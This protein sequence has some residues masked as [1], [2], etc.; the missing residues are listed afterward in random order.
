MIQDKWD[1]KSEEVPT[2]GGLE[3]HESEHQSRGHEL[4]TAPTATGSDQHVSSDELWS[5]ISASRRGA[6]SPPGV[7]G[8]WAQSTSLK[9]KDF[10]LRVLVPLTEYDY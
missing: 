9:Y 5:K 3:G 6:V 7:F 8:L 1:F 4:P 10:S 2:V